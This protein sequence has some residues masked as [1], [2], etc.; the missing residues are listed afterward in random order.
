MNHTSRS[1]VTATRKRKD[2]GELENSS[3]YK[4]SFGNSHKPLSMG[5]NNHSSTTSSST[6]TSRMV[7]PG[8]LNPSSPA[9][10]N[11]LL[12]G[13]MAHE[14]LSKGTLFGQKF[15]PARAEAVPVSAAELKRRPV[16]T[17]FETGFKPNRSYA[18]VAQL[19][20]GDGAHIPGI[21]N[22]TQLTRWIQM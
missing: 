16:Q 13:Y 3:F 14:F 11:R 8:L 18:D 1:V 2:R 15:D 6:T 5:N 9:S 22:P 20:K 21:V 19:L 7:E 17:G 12:A 10:S 4:G